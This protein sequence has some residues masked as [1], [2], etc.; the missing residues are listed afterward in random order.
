MLNSSAFRQVRDAWASDPEILSAIGF[1]L[2]WSS[3]LELLS[4]VDYQLEFRAYFDFLDAGEEHLAEAL[5]ARPDNMGIRSLNL[6]MADA[7]AAELQRRMTLGDTM[8]MVVEAVTGVD[9]AEIAEG[10]SPE[11]GPNFGGIWQDQLD[12]GRITLA[13]WGTCP[14][15][16]A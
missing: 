2:G 3:D 5:L 13:F 4:A 16:D 8:P 9:Q 1:E 12:G 10:E 7:E 15:V 14:V 11:R 6:Y